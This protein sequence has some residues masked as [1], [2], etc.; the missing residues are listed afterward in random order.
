M[1]EKS[2]GAHQRAFQ[3]GQDAW[4][5]NKHLERDNPYPPVSP[6]HDCWRQGWETERDVHYK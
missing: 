5:E 3:R 2:N 4:R 1:S 6:D